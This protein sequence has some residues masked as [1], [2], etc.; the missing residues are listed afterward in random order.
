MPNRTIARNKTKNSIKFHLRSLALRLCLLVVLLSVLCTIV[1]SQDDQPAPK[2]AGLLLRKPSGR[3]NVLGKK[4]TTTT[5]VAPADESEY[6][7]EDEA[8]AAGEQQAG[9]DEQSGADDSTAEQHAPAAATTTTTTE[10]PKKAGPL[11]RPFRSNDDLLNAL[12]RR[13]QNNKTVKKVPQAK[14]EDGSDG[15][16]V[17]VSP[18][19]APV[20]QHQYHS[21]KSTEKGECGR[22]RSILLMIEN[23][24][25]AYS[26]AGR[27][28]FGAGAGGRTAAPAAPVTEAAAEAAPQPSD[29]GASSVRRPGRSRFGLVRPV[30][31][32]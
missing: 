10:P 3:Q 32:L 11:L 1:T 25:R 19:A 18:A 29:D 26:E 15:G 5:T 17:D 12:K 6:A 9:N 14:N 27:K 2:R 23:S 31:N 13:Q 21:H 30:A 24:N 28:R 8:A 20:A 4:A 7:D 22:I 16:A